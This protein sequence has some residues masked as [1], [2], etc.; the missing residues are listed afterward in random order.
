MYQPVVAILA[1]ISSIKILSAFAHVPASTP[2]R[3]LAWNSCQQVTEARATSNNEK[4]FSGFPIPDIPPTVASALVSE[5][6]NPTHSC[7]AGGLEVRSCAWMQL[8]EETGNGRDINLSNQNE[9]HTWMRVRITSW[10]LIFTC[11]LID[12]EQALFEGEPS[13]TTQ[14]TRKLKPV[15][16]E[17]IIIISKHGATSL[18]TEPSTKNLKEEQHQ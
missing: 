1:F 5:L 18:P 15:K 10:A 4:L 2:S 12:V 3:L 17:R 7:S 9:H 6:I 8:L 14:G 11:L 16:F 13:A